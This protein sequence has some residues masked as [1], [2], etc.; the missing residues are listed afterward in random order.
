M[1][2]I[3]QPE[4]DNKCGAYCI[5]Y[6]KWININ[7]WD[8]SEYIL[9][10]SKKADQEKCVNEIYNHIK[11][12]PSDAD[13]LDLDEEFSDP[14]KMIDYLRE[15]D[16]IQQK[17]TILY[18]KNS[19]LEE[20]FGDY[21]GDGYR[22]NYTKTKLPDLN[23]GDFAILILLDDESKL[24]QHYVLVMKDES[25]KVK[26]IDPGVGDWDTEAWDDV[27]SVNISGFINSGAAIY[28]KNII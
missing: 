8:P 11:F 1:G 4:G 12:D 25:G 23:V 16:E 15:S 10:E 24:P 19:N 21:L 28:I 9:D 7:H 22:T 5:A 20:E 17:G 2:F 14:K 13:D 27:E 26:V 3:K 18:N 6:W